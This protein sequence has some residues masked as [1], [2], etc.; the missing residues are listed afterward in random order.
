MQ[1]TTLQKI[2]QSSLRILLPLNSQDLHKMCV[3]EAV[4][5]AGADYGS[6]FLEKNNQLT[7]VFSTV[8]L[9]NQLRPR[10]EGA[11]YK[12]FSQGKLKVIHK[13]TLKKTHPEAR[14]KPE[15]IVIIPLTYRDKRLGV[16]TVQSKT[17]RLYPPEL[18]QSLLLL[19]SLATLAIRNT[20]LYEH[21][22]AALHDRALFLSTT[23][24]ELKTPLTVIQT[25]GQLIQK[26]LAEQKE[27]RPKWIDTIVSSSQALQILIKDLFSLSQMSMGIFTYTYAKVDLIEV[28]RRSISNNVISYKRQI[29]LTHKTYDKREILAD[30]DK[31]ELVFNN[32]IGNAV[33]FS[34]PDTLV[35]IQVKQKDA[36]FSI[37]I[38]DKGKG[39]SK[40]DLPFVFEQYYQ[41]DHNNTAGLGLGMYLCKQ[42]IE[43]HRGMIRISSKLGVGTHV[44]IY[45]PRTID[46]RSKLRTKTS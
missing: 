2:Q 14:E 35:M 13:R 34:P 19:G 36:F 5:L 25:Y 21:T 42:I 3:K 4:S 26:Y 6:L 31:L 18:K 44:D 17:K 22:Q 30:E 32:I 28:L 8:P 11:T 9:K 33:K 46:G 43:A 24:H 1:Q 7:R 15:T 37:S 39:I 40:R 10:S 12:A 45:L 20:E 27:I 23:A 16:I 41:G 38:I 29:E